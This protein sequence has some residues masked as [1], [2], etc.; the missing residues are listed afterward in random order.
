MFGDADGVAVLVYD[1]DFRD[2]FTGFF[3]YRD[4]LIIA[5][6]GIAEIDRARKAYMVITVGGN[7]AFVI[8]G[9]V[10]ER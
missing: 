6:D 10:D 3:V 2:G 1:F 5:G 9:L 7:R 8:I 4:D